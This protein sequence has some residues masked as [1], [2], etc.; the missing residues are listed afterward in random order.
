MSSSGCA[1]VSMT[2]VGT[3]VH[4]TLCLRR[5]H[6]TSDDRRSTETI[7]WRDRTPGLCSL[8]ESTSSGGAASAAAA[9]PPSTARPSA[10]SRAP[11]SAVASA[12]AAGAR[13][14][15][16]AKRAEQ[17]GGSRA[18]AAPHDGSTPRSAGRPSAVPTD[19]VRSYD[20]GRSSRI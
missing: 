18:T 5:H 1:S 6:H 14:S 4:G 20:D 16:A 2:R 15:G 9:S 11:P 7:R 8:A 19:C 12:D 13:S 10:P 3:A 17:D